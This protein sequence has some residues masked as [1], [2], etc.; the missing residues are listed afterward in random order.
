MTPGTYT[1]TET[2]PSGWTQDPSANGWCTNVIL[3]LS[4]NG[5]TS[6]G[7]ACN[8][9]NT[10]H[11]TGS[12]KVNKLLDND[13]NGSYETLNPGTFTWS[14]DGTG[15]N[16][17]G[18]TVASVSAGTHSVNENTVSGYHITGWYRNSNG[19][20]SCTNVDSHSLPAS[21]DVVNGQTTEITICNA[22]DTGTVTVTKYNDLDA[23]GSMDAGE[24]GL[25]GWTVN[26]EDNGS[27]VT[28]SNG[29]ATF[30][31]VPTGSYELSEDLQD[32]WTQS[33]IQCFNGDEIV[34]TLSDEGY[35]ANVTA[36]STINC[37]IG[38]YQKGSIHGYK[39]N[40]LNGNGVRDELEP[41]LS[42]W[43]IFIDT[44]HNGQLDE[45]ETYFITSDSQEHFGWYW[46]ENLLPGTYSVCEVP[47]AGWNQT[48]SPV[49][50]TIQLH[51]GTNTCT[52][53]NEANSI[54]SDSVCSFGNQLIPTP[55][56]SNPG[57]TGRRT[58]RR[59]KRRT[60]KLSFM[61]CTRVRPGIR[62]NHRY[63]SPDGF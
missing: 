44:N 25:Q 5:V 43:T 14:L 56:P 34:G 8:I 37:Y 52:P 45:G 4:N 61:Y 36:G 23:N 26:L 41:L 28:D 58:K 24:P 60:F 7:G 6:W 20:A 57:G 48:S 32:S 40:D 21:V 51:D 47:K 42:G 35:Y 30:T 38:N 16:A 17:M 13:G 29:N 9:Y 39:W 59:K 54:V 10:Y 19:D 27:H 12:L 1:V 63:L 53:S 62:S 15:T 2:L 46:F 49:C 22:R 55:T 3:G 18:S 33:N 50:H 11:P 31:N